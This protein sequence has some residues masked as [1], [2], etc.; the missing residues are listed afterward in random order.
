MTGVEC[1]GIIL[2]VIPLVVEGAKVYLRG[3]EAVRDTVQSQRY[4]ASLDDF[5]IDIFCGMMEFRECMISI[6]DEL[7]ALSDTKKQA[8]VESVSEEDWKPGSEVHI[9]FQATFP[10]N[11]ELDS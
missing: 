6:L 1:A 2:V 3:L 8:L 7:P 11:M 9:A 4:D 5:Y 10:S